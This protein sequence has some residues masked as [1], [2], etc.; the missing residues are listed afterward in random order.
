MALSFSS[1]SRV[2]GGKAGQG[3][4]VILTSSA[5]IL[6]G[7]TFVATGIGLQYT[8]P[9]NLLFLRFL[10]ASIAIIPLAIVLKGRV[11][12]RMEL[13]RGPIWALG[14]VDALGFTF[15]YLG[16]GLTNAS[17]AALLSN[18]APIFVPVVALLLLKE[19]VSRAQTGGVLTGILGLVLVYSPT[20]GIGGN[21]LLGDLM[22]FMS[23]ACY[24]IF[25]VLSKRLSAVSVGSAFAIV[26]SITTFLAP[27]ALL[28]GGV[29]LTQLKMGAAGWAS[30]AYLGIACTV[31][32]ISLYLKGLK[33]TS[34]SQSA[35]LLLLELLTG[36]VLAALMLRESLGLFATIGVISISSAIFLSSRHPKN[37]K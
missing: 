13:S 28:L 10:A 32:A 7:T 23:S 26:I 15:Q 36:L 18:L 29:N 4:G 12:L 1:G 5:S 9:Y 6:W 22:L 30:I 33:S 24:T 14:G 8:N 19:G 35:T 17:D 3:A 25:I 16:Q 31:L 11:N 20:L 37:S 34:A 2:L 21:Q 27:V